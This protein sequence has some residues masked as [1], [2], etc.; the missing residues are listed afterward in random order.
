[1]RAPA[2]FDLAPSARRLNGRKRA[3]NANLAKRSCSAILPALVT[4]EVAEQADATV[5]KTVE[6]YAHVGSIPTFGTRPDGLSAANAGIIRPV[7]ELANFEGRTKGIGRPAVRF[8]CLCYN[9]RRRTLLL[10]LPALQP[11]DRTVTILW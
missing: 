7:A 11:G 2:R 3:Q 1:M 6:H 10:R 4:A 9:Q 8:P 5:S